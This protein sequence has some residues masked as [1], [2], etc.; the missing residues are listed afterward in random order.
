MIA[1]VIIPVF[2]G[3]YIFVS[4]HIKNKGKESSQRKKAVTN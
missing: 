2:V 4:K 1:V 3:I